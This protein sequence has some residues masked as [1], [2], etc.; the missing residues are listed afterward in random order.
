MVR[1]QYWIDLIEHYWRTRNILWLSGV[2]R[3]GKTCLAQS[4]ENVTYL[5]CEL[6][7]TRRALEDPEGF[8]EAH[9]G[10]R[11][12]LDEIHRLQNP[13]EV[14]KIA[15]DHYP[16]IRILA[17]GSSSLGA[18]ARF[19]DTLA[20]RKLELWLT[21]MILEDLGYFDNPS[22]EHRLLRGGLPP[23]F[24]SN[25]N[26]AK[27]YQEWLDAFWAKDILELFRLERRYSFLRF[28]ELLF[29][30][31]GGMF[32]ASRFAV[33]CEVSRTTIANYLSVLEATYIVH[34][35]RPFSSHRSTEIVSAPKVYGFDTGFVCFNKGWSSLRAEDLGLLWEHFVLN[36]LQAKLQARNIRYWRDKSGH[37]VDFVLAHASHRLTAIES[38]WAAASFDPASLLALRR[39]YPHGKNYVVTQDTRRRHSR[40]YHSIQVEF[41]SLRELVEE[42]ATRAR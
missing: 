28:A 42:L 37:E 6:P 17:T 27:E 2:R 29:A 36:E 24:L 30:Q 7:S 35:L 5:D 8:L 38:K 19:R 9:S 32:E 15:A 21:P 41:V 20:G 23:F 1:R 16:G 25:T 14:L 22:L 18:S 33:A 11:L 3:V 13:S 26:P 12:V 40:R 31:S 10:M 4:L 39:S 34:L